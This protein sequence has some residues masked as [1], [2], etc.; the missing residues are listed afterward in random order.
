[1]KTL[2]LN[3]AKTHFSNVLK[4][5]EAGNEIAISRGK[6]NETIAIIVPYQTWKKIK[7]RE[8]GTLK[9][10]AKVKFATDFSITD[11][12]LLNS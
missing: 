11:E 2:Q 5:V 10:K 8:L 1:M 6:T 7:K 9:G 12:E 3:E 4:E